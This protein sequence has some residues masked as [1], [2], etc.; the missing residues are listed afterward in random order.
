MAVLLSK[1]TA[2]KVLDLISDHEGTPVNKAGA[3][4]EFRAVKD[5]RYVRITAQATD[6][7]S[8]DPIPNMWEAEEV[9]Y[10]TD[11]NDW[12]TDD[13]GFIYY[14]ETAFVI[15]QDGE[16]GDVVSINAIT[17][18]DGS[19]FWL[20][21]KGG[22]A[23]VNLL[24]NFAVVDA[25]TGEYSG[26]IIDNP[27]DQAVLV[28]GV[29]VKVL[30]ATENFD[31]LTDVGPLFAANTYQEDD[32]ASTEEPPAKRTVYYVTAPVLF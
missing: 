26:D 21:I 2:G 6:D 29:V 20:G 14:S 31:V 16:V 13:P 5:L 15:V 12:V 27:T 32:P 22:S 28:S 3:G 24:N 19:I 9:R 17:V 11:E 30:K 18:V 4:G 10:D 25:V 7:V 23:A 1:A 8:G